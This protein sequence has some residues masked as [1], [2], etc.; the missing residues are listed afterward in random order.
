LP[1]QPTD[2]V[3]SG[4]GLTVQILNGKPFQR[5][6]QFILDSQKFLQNE[7]LAIS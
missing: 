2:A 3:K 1:G 7:L 5:L 4:A 6:P